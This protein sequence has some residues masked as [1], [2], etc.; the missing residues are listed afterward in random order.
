MFAFENNFS[1][2]MVCLK[3]VKDSPLRTSV[4]VE[5][6]SSIRMI[7]HHFEQLAKCRHLRDTAFRKALPEDIQVA[8]KVIGYLDVEPCRCKFCRVMDGDQNPYAIVPYEGPKQVAGMEKQVDRRRSFDE[9][10]SGRE[11]SSY[12]GS[13]R[14][15]SDVGWMEGR[16]SPSL[17]PSQD[18]Y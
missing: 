13:P 15:L 6:C 11:S 2:G 7:A 5:T 8:K 4:V 16:R 9:V 17:S 12:M 1:S 18:S 3:V 10:S 14:P